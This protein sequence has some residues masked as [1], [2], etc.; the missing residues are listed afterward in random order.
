MV[1]GREFQRVKIPFLVGYQADNGEKKLSVTT[2]LAAGGI[3]FTVDKEMS[4]GARLKIQ[5][6]IPW[7]EEPIDSEVEVLR[8][9][10]ILKSDSFEVATRFLALKENNS[11]EI[12][13]IVFLM[14]KELRLHQLF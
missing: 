5:L 11:Q 3:R 12:A 1:S 14:Q 2:D 13:K 9:A 6:R 7:R 4:E 8:C 10:K